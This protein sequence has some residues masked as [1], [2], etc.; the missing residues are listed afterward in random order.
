MEHLHIRDTVKVLRQRLD[1]SESELLRHI[2][3]AGRR[4]IQELFCS[5]QSLRNAFRRINKCDA[6]DIDLFKVLFQGGRE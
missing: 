4:D 6:L 3:A 1:I 2:I 5:A